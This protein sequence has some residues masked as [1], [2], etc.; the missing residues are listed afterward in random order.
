MEENAYRNVEVV[1]NT[2]DLSHT[3][4][5]KIYNVNLKKWNLLFRLNTNRSFAIHV[6]VPAVTSVVFNSKFSNR[7]QHM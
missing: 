5:R 1:E 2:C 3:H 6:H 7:S 4:V